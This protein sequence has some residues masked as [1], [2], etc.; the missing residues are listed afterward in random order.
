MSS[1][2]VSGFKLVCRPSA[3]GV[4]MMQF[5]DMGLD[6]YDVADGIKMHKPHR[7]DEKC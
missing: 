3:I 6:E 1:V 2:P 4:G 7:I 5:Y